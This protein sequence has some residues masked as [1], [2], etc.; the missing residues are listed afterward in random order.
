[1][2]IVIKI[3]ANHFEAYFKLFVATF[4]IILLHLGQSQHVETHD[5]NKLSSYVPP[6]PPAVL[7]QIFLCEGG[8]QTKTVLSVDH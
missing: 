1:M 5:T 8:S 4:H 6:L 7:C 3:F 2:K